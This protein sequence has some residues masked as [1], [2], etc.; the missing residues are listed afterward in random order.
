MRA[1][2]LKSAGRLSI[3]IGFVVFAAAAPLGAQSLP[4]ALADSDLQQI[5]GREGTTQAN[6][7]NQASGVNNSQVNGNSVTGQILMDGSSFQDFSGLAVFNANTGN[8]VSI[9]ASMQ[10]NISITPPGQ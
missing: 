6:I 9:N 4:V 5:T 1:Y 10:V 7:S 2:K 3:A 8:N